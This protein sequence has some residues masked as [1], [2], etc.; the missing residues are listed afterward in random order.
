M[1]CY[2]RSFLLYQEWSWHYHR[3]KIS[4]YSCES[5]FRSTAIEF[6]YSYLISLDRWVWRCYQQK[7][8]RSFRQ[9][10]EVVFYHLLLSWRFWVWTEYREHVLQFTKIISYEKQEEDELCL[11]MLMKNILIV[12]LGFNEKSMEIWHDG[13]IKEGVKIYEQFFNNFDLWNI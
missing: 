10:I 1:K 9:P 2:T 5:L 4:C 3:S 8:W 12:F 6:W 13:C 7:W 11:F